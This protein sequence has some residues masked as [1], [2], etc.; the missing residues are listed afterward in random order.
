MQGLDIGPESVTKF[1]EVIGRAKTIVWNGYA[2]FLRYDRFLGSASQEYALSSSMC[3]DSWNDLRRTFRPPG[4]FEFE[5]FS[6]G[7]RAMMDAVVHAT[8]KGA[9]SIIG[10]Y[11]M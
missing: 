1:T 4:V 8:G 2:H 10:L 6:K 3:N 11:L 5:N 7:T 9:T